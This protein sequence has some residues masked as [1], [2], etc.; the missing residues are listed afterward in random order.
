LYHTDYIGWQFGLAVT[1]C[2]TSDPVSTRTGDRQWTGK[3][4]RCVTSQLGQ[5]SL[6]PSVGR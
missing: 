5:L 2:A 6:L 1:C 4:S 3:P